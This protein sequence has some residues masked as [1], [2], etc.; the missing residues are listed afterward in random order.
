MLPRGCWTKAAHSSLYSPLASAGRS[1]SMAQLSM[2]PTG[3]NSSPQKLVLA[4][5]SGTQSLQ[6]QPGGFLGRHGAPTPRC[7]SSSS[8]HTAKH[9]S[10][11]MPLGSARE[12]P[13]L[14]KLPWQ[15]TGTGCATFALPRRT[16]ALWCLAGISG[17]V[18]AAEP[19][20]QAPPRSDTRWCHPAWVLSL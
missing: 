17:A 3:L 1:P 13:G 2:S 11:P 10:K 5:L 20:T 6:P 8:H 16:S 4:G 9:P 14:Q 15:D 19:G 18:E 12:H 7:P